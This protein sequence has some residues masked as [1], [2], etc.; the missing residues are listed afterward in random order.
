M[1]TL[2][3]LST[4]MTSPGPAASMARAPRWILGAPAGAGPSASFVVTAL[5]RTRAP[6]HI[7]TRQST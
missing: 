1:L 5:P 3:S 4:T 2:P 7:G 6:T